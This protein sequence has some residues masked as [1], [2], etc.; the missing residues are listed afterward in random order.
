MSEKQLK[1]ADKSKI[2]WLIT[3]VPFILIMGL[4]FLLFIFPDQANSVISQVRFFFG[5]TLGSYYI[6]IGIGVLVISIFLSFSKYGNIVLGEP[7]EK[8]KYNFF[9]WGSMMF[10]C[11]LAADILFYSFAEWAEALRSGQVCF[12]C[13]TGA[14]SHGRSIL[15]SL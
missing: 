8:P 11:G 14:L 1:T 4:A 9:T 2:D 7:Y 12:R 3:L 13:S 6:I 5:D 10:T 15:F